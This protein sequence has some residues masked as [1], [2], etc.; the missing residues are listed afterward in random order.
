[1]AIQ[2]HV[3]RIDREE[4]TGWAYDPGDHATALTVTAE[5]KSVPI[6]T[7]IANRFHGGLKSAGKGNGHN[8]FRVVFNSAIGDADL[9]G[10]S[11]YAAAP[12]AGVRA[13][14][15]LPSALAPPRTPA[16]FDDAKIRQLLRQGLAYAQ[17][18]DLLPPAGYPVDFIDSR[19][20]AKHAMLQDWLAQA[21]ATEEEAK[22]AIRRDTVPIPHL[23]NREGYSPGFELGYWMSGYAHYR[24]LKDN[25]AARYGLHSGRY[26]DFGGSTGRIFRHFALQ[27]TAWEVWSCDFKPASVAFNQKYFPSHVRVFLNTSFP[28]L[29]VQADYFDII[30]A[31]SVFTHINESETGWLLELRRLLRPGG[32]ACL[33][34]HSEE[35][36]RDMGGGDSPNVQKFR[37]D[38]AGAAELPPGKTVVMF[39]DD[40]PY[41]CNVYHTNDYIRQNWGRFFEICEIIP[42]YL[43]GKQAMV[44]CR[45]AD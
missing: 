35:T 32:I 22:S 2:A 26:L 38:L 6:G 25:I 19:D 16:P 8:G 13:P 28:Y 7:A 23:H 34:I 3:D 12:G 18:G 40:D 20:F 42:Y 9:A 27:S 5:L 31:F 39:R 37:P 41:N 15:K 33:T 21:N 24:R 29:P 30:S 17:S 43:N 4:L 36:W 45:R 1:M 44:V 11:V 10:L 14:L